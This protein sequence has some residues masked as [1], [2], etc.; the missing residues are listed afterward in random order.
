MINIPVADVRQWQTVLVFFYQMFQE[1]IRDEEGHSAPPF[2]IFTL[3]DVCAF[4]NEG[5]YTFFHFPGFL[6]FMKYSPATHHIDD[7]VVLQVKSGISLGL[8]AV[9]MREEQILAMQLPRHARKVLE[10]FVQVDDH[11]P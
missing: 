3:G 11:K 5:A 7:E 1:V 6:V 2:I 8:R 9:V 4:L 10:G